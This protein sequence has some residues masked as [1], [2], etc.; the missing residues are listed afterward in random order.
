[1]LS[2]KDFGKNFEWG[3]AIAAAQNEG[4]ATEDGKGLSI[5]DVYARRTGKIKGGGKPAVGCDF[6]HRYK[7]DL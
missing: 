4:A 1:M 3:V 5:W 2:A 6:Y 7:D